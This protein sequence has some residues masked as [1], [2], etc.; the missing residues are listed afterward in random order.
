MI[1]PRVSAALHRGFMACCVVGR[2]LP[3]IA[4]GRGAQDAGDRRG[5]ARFLAAGRRRQDVHARRFRRRQHPGHHLHVQPLPDGPGVRGADQA[6]GRRLQGPRRGGGGRFA[7]RRGGG[8][9]RRARLH[10]PGRLARR[11]EDPRPRPRVQFPVSLRRRDAGDVA[12]PTAR[13]PRRTCSSSTA[14]AS[15]AS[16]AGSTTTRT[17]P[18]PRRTTRATRSTRCWPA[19]R[20]RSKRRAPSAARSN[21]P[22]RRRRRPA[23]LAKWDKETGRA[24]NDRRGRPRRAGGEQDATSSA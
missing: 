3:A 23:A 16:A 15:C 13:S 22:T 6:A 24:E 11:H 1:S 18:R 14:T 17:R 8:A 2:R 9:A 4:V 5:R 12:T 10:R 7:E 19:S 20:C 21:G